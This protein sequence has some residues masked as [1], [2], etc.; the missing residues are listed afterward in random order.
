MYSPVGIDPSRSAATLADD[1][2]ENSVLLVGRGLLGNLVGWQPCNMSCKFPLSLYQSPSTIPCFLIAFCTWI[3]LDGL[4]EPNSTFSFEDP[5]LLQFE[6]SIE[7]HDR[8]S[9]AHPTHACSPWVPLIGP[10]KNDVP[11]TL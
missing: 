7:L 8:L 9:S 5:A 4:H 3:F 1:P 2:V 11:N 6:N 10:S